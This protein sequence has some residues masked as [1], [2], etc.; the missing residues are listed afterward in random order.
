MADDDETV[1]LLQPTGYFT[2]VE[3]GTTPEEQFITCQQEYGGEPENA[4]EGCL[5]YGELRKCVIADLDVA[6]R[7]SLKNW[8]Y[9]FLCNDVNLND[10]LESSEFAS[11]L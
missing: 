2:D 6:G 7:L 10:C 8:R 1:C 5:T 3:L 4:G 9:K 11:M